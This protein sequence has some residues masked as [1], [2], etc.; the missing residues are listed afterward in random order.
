MYVRVLEVPHLDVRR[1]QVGDLGD[2]RVGGRVPHDD[3]RAGLPRRHHRDRGLVLGELH[4][5]VGVDVADEDRRVLVHA[6]RGEVELGGRATVADLE[7]DAGALARAGIDEIGDHAVALDLGRL[8]GRRRRRA[9]SGRPRDTS[10]SGR[11]PGSGRPSTGRPAAPA[12]ADVEAPAAVVVAPELLL[13]LPHAEATTARAA[14]EA[15]ASAVPL[16]CARMVRRL[17]SWTWWG[18]GARVRPR[19]GAPHGSP[20]RFTRCS[21]RP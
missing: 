8:P 3:L 18:G 16:R 12:P 4:G 6:D 1:L 15:A 5:L 7:L 9:P 2:V 14:S 17:L 21:R 13:S 10:R 19:P 20:V 11:R